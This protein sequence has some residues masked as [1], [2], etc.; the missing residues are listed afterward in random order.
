MDDAPDRMTVQAFQPA[1]SVSWVIEPF[2]WTIRFNKEVDESTI[3]NK[4]I[5]ILNHHHEVE[6]VN[7]LL[8]DDKKSIIVQPPLKGYEQ[9]MTYYMHIESGLKSVKDDAI[10]MPARFSFTIKR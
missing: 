3:T 2:V 7:L 4:Q 5:Y 1:D 9:G 6:N 8:G 10:S